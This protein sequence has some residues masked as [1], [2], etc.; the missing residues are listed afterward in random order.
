[1][2]DTLLKFHFFPPHPTKVE[3]GRVARDTEAVILF[4]EVKSAKGKQMVQ[5]KKPRYRTILVKRGKYSNNGIKSI[6][7]KSR[8][9]NLSFS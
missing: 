6:V 1:M 4:A 9:M 7:D 3:E 5:I 8:R 2:S